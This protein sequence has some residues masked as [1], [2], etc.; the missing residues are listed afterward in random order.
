MRD[1]YEVLG[2]SRNATEEEITKAYRELAKKYHPDLNPGDATAAQRMSEINEAYDRIRSGDTQPVYG[3]YTYGAGQASRPGTGGTGQ[4]DPFGEFWR[5]YAAAQQQARQQ[6]QQ[7]QYQQ[8]RQQQARQQQQY[9]QY[10]RYNQYPYWR[11][12]Y[13]R[14]GG[15]GCFRFLLWFIGIQFLLG[16][17]SVILNM[18]GTGGY[19]YYNSQDPSANQDSGGNSYYE[20]TVPAPS[21]GNSLTMQTETG[22]YLVEFV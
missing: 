13:R 1:P 18:C 8:Y 22:D 2:V 9:Q 12:T 4:T 10:R 11:Q 14:S 6:Q 5:W 20:F 17:F 15:F 16:L 21:G 19:Y 3:P 7:Q